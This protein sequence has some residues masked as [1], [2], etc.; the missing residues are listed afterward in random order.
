MESADSAVSRR[1]FVAAGCASGGLLGATATNGQPDDAKRSVYESLGIRSVINATGTVTVL[2]GSVMPPEVVAAWADAARHFVD[3]VELQER[4][5]DRIA[6]LAGVEAALVTSGAAGA[7]VLGAAAAVTRGDAARIARL[8]DTTGMPN[9]II[10]QKAHRSCYD[11]QLTAVGARLVEVATRDE[12]ERAISDRTALLFFMNVNDGDGQIRRAEW[13]EVAR[14]H[15]IATLLDAAADVPP[16]ERL[17]EYIRMGFDL[18]AFSGGKAMRGPN[19]TGLLIG[20]RDLIHAAKRNTNP[21]CGTLG[22][23]MKVSKEDMVACLAAVERFV[24]IDHAAEWREWERRIQVIEEALADLPALRT[25]RVVPP[26]ANHVPH[27]VVTWDE[28]KL[29]LTPDA[30]TRQ[31]ADSDPCIRI[32]R[33]RHTGDRGICI[34]VF[35]L[36]PGDESVVARRLR[37]IFVVPA[38]RSADHA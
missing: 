20:R 24:R 30:V 4:V 5:G 2:G 31:L 19:D 6:Q 29:D 27:L 32:G 11:N 3:L 16:V 9:E 38:T 23:A 15:G 36:Q 14:R 28:R 37:E 10:L 8:P 35:T 17:S 22:R 7:L 1:E 12:L 18:V 34:S 25:E 33:V 26:I 21:N 13:G